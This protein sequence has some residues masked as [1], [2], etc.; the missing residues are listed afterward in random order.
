MADIVS[1]LKKGG[2]GVMPTDTIYGLVG[3]A[4]NPDTVERIY[5]V[6]RRDLKKPFL[7]LISSIKDLE[8]F[9]VD[10]SSFDK[11]ILKEYWPGKVTIIL[12]LSKTSIEKFRYLHRGNN[13]LA[14]RLPKKAELISLLKKTGPLIAPSAN[15][16]GGL[17]SRNLKEAKV[18]FGENVDFYIS[19]KV[20]KK[21]SKIITLISGAVNTVRV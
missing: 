7:I 13:T 10:F 16:S 9:E 21:S 3:S 6:R 20:S 1:M 17:P 11:K 4:M 12:P 19:G 2:I 15:I 8:K 5:K 14:F 18:Y